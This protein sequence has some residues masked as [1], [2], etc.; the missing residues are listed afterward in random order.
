MYVE[1]RG[2]VGKNERFPTQAEVER[3]HQAAKSN[4]VVGLD[5]RHLSKGRCRSLV[6]TKALTRGYHGPVILAPASR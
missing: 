5:E 2:R 6:S 3:L 4:A 1:T